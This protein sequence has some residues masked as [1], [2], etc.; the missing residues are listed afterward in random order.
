MKYLISLLTLLS[1]TFCSSNQ[2]NAEVSSPS[3]SSDFQEIPKIQ[4]GFSAKG[5]LQAAEQVAL[6]DK[7]LDDFPQ[8]LKDNLHIRVSGGTRSQKE[9]PNDWKDS[10][11]RLWTDLQKKHGFKFVFVVNGN[12]TPQSQKQFYQK[13]VGFGA[14]F[15]FVEMMNE[16]YMTKFRT[17]DKSKPEVTRAITPEVYA[18]DLLPKFINE[19]KSLDIPLFVIFAPEKEGKKNNTYLK[20]WNNVV[21]SAI[22]KNF[23]DVKIGVTVHLYEKGETNYNYQ[24]LIRL[25]EMLPQGVPIAVTEAGS[26][27]PKIRDYD[28]AGKTIY[29]HYKSIAMHL[30]PGD[31]LFDQTLYNNYS[32]NTMATLHSSYNGITPKGEQ[33]VKFMKEMYPD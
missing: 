13:W 25:R 23:K 5:S 14:Q 8:G 17:G 33:V 11:I 7:M 30:R 28:S 27:D 18:E 15:S 3:D 32:N 2:P 29:K 10:D 20:E 9:M 31:Y 26:L 19:F 1:L 22:K 24:Q 6:T 4:L 16:Y 12:D 21:A